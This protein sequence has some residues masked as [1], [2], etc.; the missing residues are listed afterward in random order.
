LPSTEEDRIKLNEA[1]RAHLESCISPT[2]HR[3]YTWEQ[4]TTLAE[5]AAEIDWQCDFDAQGKCKTARAAPYEDPP[6]GHIVGNNDRNCCF[7]C[8]ANKGFLEKVPKDAVPRILAL[9]DPSLGFWAAEEGCRLPWRWRSHVC[10][11]YSCRPDCKSLFTLLEQFRA[12]TAT[13]P[14]RPGLNDKQIAEL[15]EQLRRDGMFKSSTPQATGYVWEVEERLQ[16]GGR[17]NDPMCQSDP[18]GSRG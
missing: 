17:I 13:Y 3:G 10:L 18:E 16:P 12:V 8:S 6:L 14:W 1:M 7:Y 5:T 4:W 9:Y 11:G 2:A 15:T